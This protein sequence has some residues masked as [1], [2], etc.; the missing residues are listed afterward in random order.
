MTSET[1]VQEALEA[2]AWELVLDRSTGAVR[3]LNRSP[4]FIKPRLVTSHSRHQD[5]LS[6]LERDPLFKNLFPDDDETKHRIRSHRP[7]SVAHQLINAALWRCAQKGSLT[8]DCVL[9]Q[10]RSGLDGVRAL[11]S[12]HPVKTPVWVGFGADLPADSQ[13]QTP[14][15]ILGSVEI[16]VG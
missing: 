15:G 10:I 13:V 3:D 4:P 8:S 7:S 11:V 12:R 14:W 16:Q 2:L 1:D 5:F 9:E 6:T